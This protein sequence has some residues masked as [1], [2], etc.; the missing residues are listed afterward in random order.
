MKITDLMS[1]AEHKPDSEQ[2]I[3]FS[4]IYYTYYVS[5]RRELLRQKVKRKRRSYTGEKT[6]AVEL[7]NAENKQIELRLKNL[8]QTFQQIQR[9]DE[10]SKKAA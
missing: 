10:F 3:P 4:I 9:K 5:D 8:Y 1:F 6:V 2:S 7:T